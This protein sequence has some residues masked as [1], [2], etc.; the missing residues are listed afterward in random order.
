M[1][2]AESDMSAKV[3]ETS[4]TKITVTVELVRNEHF[5]KAYKTILSTALFL[6]SCQ[7]HHVAL[8]HLLDFTKT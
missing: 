7:V 5:I 8:A 6:F 3:I 2:S 4:G 1:V